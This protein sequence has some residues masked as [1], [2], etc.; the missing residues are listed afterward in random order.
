MDAHVHLYDPAL[1]RAALEAAAKNFAACCPVASRIGVL[2]L[3]ETN[4]HDAFSR[5]RALER[6]DAPELAATE[7]ASLWLSTGGWR[8]LAIA[9]RQ[10]VTAERL[11]VLALGTRTRFED[12]EPLDRVLAR[13]AAEDAIAVL[14]WGCGKWT[15]SRARIIERVIAG[16][17]PLQVF[18]GDNGGRPQLWPERLF[19]AASKRGLRNLPGSDPLPLPNEWRRIGRFGVALSAPLSAETPLSD[20]KAALR[21]PAQ[22]FRA[23]GRLE[24]TGRFVRNQLLL[25]TRN[26]RLPLAR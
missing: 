9:G 5:L 15:G 12:G 3:A 14:P 24:S 16:G 8:L 21:D 20:L 26:P 22:V 13:V 10:V 6:S 2:M 11:E 18:V 17:D 25:R 7:P 23:Y 1:D 4:G 19:D